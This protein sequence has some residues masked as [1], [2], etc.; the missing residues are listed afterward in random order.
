MIVS[1]F[2]YALGRKTYIVSE[3]AEWLRNNVSLISD[4]DKELMI[5]EITRAEEDD[6]LGWDCDKQEWLKLKEVLANE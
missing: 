3:T 4:R 2:R 6:R 5:K 1:S